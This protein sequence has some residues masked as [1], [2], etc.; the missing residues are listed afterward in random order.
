MNLIRL[1]VLMSSALPCA[2]VLAQ[3]QGNNCLSSFEKASGWTLLFDGKSTDTWRGYQKKG[4]PEQGWKVEDGC[5]HVVAG[6][7]GGDIITK[8]Q[9]A[10]FD[11]SIEWKVSPQANSGIIYRASEDLGAPWQTGPEYQVLDDAGNNMDPTAKHAAGSL[12]D[13]YG[14]SADKVLRPVG[15]FNQTHILIRN[16]HVTHWLNGVKVLEYD[17]DSKEWKEAIAGSKFR[18]Y[19][20]FGMQPRGHIAL[21]DHGH[22]VWFRNIKIREIGQPLP[23]ERA[24]FD[25]QSLTGWGA[26]LSEK[27]D[28][29]SVWSVANG[30]L[31][32]KGQPAGY[33]YTKDE[34]ANF[35]L[36]L[37][38]R[39]SPVTKQAGNSGVLLRV[40]GKDKV[41]PD[42]IEAQL[43][44]GN[45]GD[46]WNIG[47]F[48]MQTDPVRLNGRN[49][50]KTHF[51]EKPIGE[52]NEYE[53]FV[54]HGDIVL[55]VN[56]EL[57]NNAW[58]VKE[59]AGRIAL[60]SEGAEIHFRNM[61]VAPVK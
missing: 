21:Q 46:F 16:N 3:D 17:L 47:E 18:D 32:C 54:N 25:G 22:D 36:R 33:I 35:V 59:I 24:L 9:Y 11:L 2:L 43:Q 61:R 60:Q 30:I 1:F 28:P 4:F 38:W 15:E 44:S 39:W 50:K 57:V 52:W 26:F 53:I 5:L 42:C 20:G 13:I 8:Q 51:A 34:F 27:V 45:A 49:T 7:N 37:E 12:F 10:D 41:W 40:I 19:E 58:D 31:L 14:P 23:G 55:Y 48:P 6:G 29:D 56:G